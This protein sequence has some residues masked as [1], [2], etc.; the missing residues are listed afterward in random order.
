MTHVLTFAEARDQ[1]AEVVRSREA[2]VVLGAGASA[3]SG[4]PLTDELI[5]RLREQFRLADLDSRNTLFD[6]CSTVCDTPP[7]DRKQLVRFVVDQF[8]HLEPSPSYRQLPRI[9][10]HALFTTNYDDL[11]EKTY[12]TPSKT[13][14]LR[15]VSLSNPE[16]IIPR[17]RELLLFRLMGSIRPGASDLDWPVLSWAD[18]HRSVERRALI[19]DLIKNILADGGHIIYVGYSFNDFILDGVL[20]SALSRIGARN[21]PYGYAI[22]TDWPDDRSQPYYKIQSRKV[23]PVEGSFDEFAGLLREVADDEQGPTAKRRPPPPAPAEGITLT[24]RGG[25]IQLSEDEA[26]VYSEL[27]EVVDESVVHEEEL[28]PESRADLAKSFLRGERL[29]WLPFSQGWFFKRFAYND[30]FATVA[31]NCESTDPHDNEVFLVHGPAG[32]GKSVMARQAAWDAYTKLQIPVLVGKANW[33]ANP[34]LRLLDR[35]CF[36]LES[37]LPDDQVLPRLL[38]VVDEAELLDRSLPSRMTAYLRSRNRAVSILLFARTNEYF[39]LARPGEEATHELWGTPK[40]IRLEE[41]LSPE[42]TKELIRHIARLGIWEKNRTTAE[43][44]WQA[45]I[46]AEL[47]YSFFD[48]LYSL[49]EQTQQPLRD[50]I[51][52]EYENLGALAK[53]AYLL[54]SATHQFGLPLKMEV[55]QRALNVVFAEFEDSVI[56]SDARRVLFTEHQSSELN[57]FFRG[58]TRLISRLI[59]EQA[60]PDTAKQLEV[61]K[62]IA[63]A[64]NP[65]EMF[66]ADELNTL[67]V[68]LVQV[69]GSHGFDTRFAP[70][71][72]AELFA[73]ATQHIEDDVLE[74]HYGLIERDRKAFLS[75][76]DHL[77]K[78]LRLSAELPFDLAT[79][80]E[81][82]QHIENSLALVIGELGLEA[83][84]RG[85]HQEATALFD[86]AR[87]HFVNARSGRFPNAAAYDAHARML[88]TRALRLFSLGSAERALGLSEALDVLSEGIDNVN[89]DARPPLVALQAQIL[90]ELGQEDT[91]IEAVEK[92]MKE[93]T[94]EE[95]SRYHILLARLLLSKRGGKP[96]R[97]DLREAHR[98]ASDACEA[99]PRYFPAWRLRAEIYQRLHPEHHEGLFDLLSE[100]LKHAQDA[101]NNCWAI[102][103]LAVAAFY[104]ERYG[105]SYRWFRQLS[106][107]SR[108]HENRSGILE[109]AGADDK[110]GPFEFVGEVI[111]STRGEYCVRSEEL[112]E[113]GDIYFNS[114]AQRYY[115][116]RLHDNVSFEIGFNYRG[117]IA[118]DLRRI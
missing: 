82:P 16:F 104:L 71:E 86:E 97:R 20:D 49:V 111:K 99:D 10:W 70:D 87:N 116:P 105:T 83:L 33:R 40:Q 31:E 62:T 44:F 7:Y 72:T 32:L 79:V 51:W 96:K 57:L 68:L 56:R 92:R 67:R 23:I 39:R 37:G 74:H 91:A 1:L 8:E 107:I 4:A 30:V 45:Y 58:R 42:E 94:P 34:D 81:S 27:L 36:D 114:R 41:K 38:L 26:A 102:F 93:S 47:H 48:T 113:F 66:G 43:S 65:S 78:A 52:S 55:L 75:A 2:A 13:Q 50:R 5:Q 54:I 110:D 46:E 11:L 14:T 22:L 35:F 60:V 19:L 106:R 76:R 18:Y 53:E 24:L 90:T 98:H 108:G 17:E 88:R 59:F 118:L 73:E 84:K 95:R 21:M 100:T 9:H 61:F 6:I 69:F 15:S 77:E 29:G 109:T 80:R 89:H 115:T 112:S 63:R 12:T 85:K 25:D 117:P 28:D 3:S 101:E 64:T 103:R